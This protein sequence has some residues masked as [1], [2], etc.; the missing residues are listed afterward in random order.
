MRPEPAAP[1]HSA[2]FLGEV[3]HRR[4]APTRHDLRF[5]LFMV[6]LDLSEGRRAFDGRWLW[7]F[8][9]R[10][11]AAFHR[12][13]YLPG[14]EGEP[15]EDTVR[16]LVREKTGADPAGPVRML[17]HL[18][19]FGHCF[20]PVTFYYCFK[21]DGQTL[22]AVVSEITNTPWKEKHVDVL[23]VEES[24][25]GADRL[26]F[27][28]DKNFHVSPFMPMEMRYDWRFRVPPREDGGRLSVHMQNTPRAGCDARYGEGRPVFE[29]TLL[30]KRRPLSGPWMAFALLRFPF[31]TLQV[32]AGIYLHAALLW[33]KKTPFVP[34]P[35]A[36]ASLS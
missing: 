5:P 7:S 20:N 32:L 14:R 9:K 19:Y 36:T 34:H 2:L 17:T 29:A 24:L 22:A 12:G 25:E 27:R 30:M 23:P 8:G 21:P 35:P 18:R 1:P 4:F 16:R 15:L 10:N 6:Y 26:H 3:T 33:L 11:V 13:D 28:F 31:L